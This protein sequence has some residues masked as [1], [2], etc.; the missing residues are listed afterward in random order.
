MLW[1][2]SKERWDFNKRW[3]AIR[4]ALDH[5]QLLALVLG[6]TFGWALDYKQQ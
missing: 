2:L 6:P 1:T 5:L 3:V 4:L